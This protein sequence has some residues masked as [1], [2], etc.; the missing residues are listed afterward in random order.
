MHAK[1]QALSCLGRARVLTLSGA[2]GSLINENSGILNLF[3]P[4]RPVSI[5]I[6][7]HGKHFIRSAR[8]GG[9]RGPAGCVCRSRESGK[10]F[11]NEILRRAKPCES[12]ARFSARNPQAVQQ[13][14]DT[15]RQ[16][17]RNV[18]VDVRQEIEAI[19]RLWRASTASTKRRLSRTSGA[20]LGRASG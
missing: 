10:C 13:Q 18:A 14:S 12:R 19:C 7:E 8:A 1:L 5:F 4:T 3:D 16:D 11:A 20:S 9:I 2:S 15:D 17:A 6:I